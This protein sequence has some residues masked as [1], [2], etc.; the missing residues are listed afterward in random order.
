[1]SVTLKSGNL[2]DF[3]ASA[4]ETA[5]EIDEGRPVTRKNIIWVDPAD[6]RALLKP[7][8][9]NLV[10]FL[11]DKE[12]V[13][14]SELLQAMSRTPASLNNDLDILLKYQLVRV[15]KEPNPGHGVR[16]VI[17]PTYGRQ[18]I[19]FIAEI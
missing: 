19:E 12:R 13:V 11:R 5:R 3:F 18:K 6:L 17:E 1:M 2:S 4:K 14:F 8:R 15:Y 16:K 9:T 7:E 10:R